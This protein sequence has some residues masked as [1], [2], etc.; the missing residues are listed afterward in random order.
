LI[1]DSTSHIYNFEAGGTSALSGVQCRP[2]QTEGGLL[3]AEQVEAAI[4]PP[5]LPRARTG[6]ISVENTHNRG[7]GAIYQL[8]PLQAIAAVAED[9]GVPVHMDGARVFNAGVGS[10]I[11]VS[12]FARHASTLSFC[13]SKGL[14][15]PFGSLLTGPKDLIDEGR[16]YRQ[17]FGGGM[18]QAGIM[19]AAGIYALK[20]HVERLAEDHT[21]AARLAEGLGGLPGVDLPFGLTRTNIVV[22][23]I[24]ES[25]KKAPAVGAALKERGVLVSVLGETRFRALTHMDVT[26]DDIGRALKEIAAC[27]KA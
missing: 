13:L 18:R 22:F 8:E 21:K 12:E 11:P 4:Q 17:V 25:G 5:T 9:N 20:H 10:D 3:S 1:A 6:L 23:D 24:A 14:G 7:G 27:M 16:R 2:V 26:M 15:T 19:A